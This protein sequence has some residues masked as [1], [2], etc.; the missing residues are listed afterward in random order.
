[1]DGLGLRE[2]G[3]GVMKFVILKVGVVFVLLV[4]GLI[5]VR[6]VFWKEDNEVIFFVS[7]LELI[8][9]FSRRNDGEEEEEYIESLGDY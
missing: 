2:G 1:M 5:L 6:F 7:N 8:L 4:I 3:G 9:L